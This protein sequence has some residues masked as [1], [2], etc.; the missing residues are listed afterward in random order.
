V[1]LARKSLLNERSKTIMISA[2]FR[3][4]KKRANVLGREMAYVETVSG[5][6]IVFLH[7]NPTS[8]YLWRNVIPYLQ[9]LGRCLAPDLI[10]MGDSE[11]LP[12]SGPGSYTLV[13]HSRYLDALLEGLGVNGRVTLVIHDWGGVLGFHWA[14]RH[15]EAVKGIAYMEALVRPLLWAEW[16]EQVRAL[17]QALRSPAGETMVLEHNFF[18][19]S[20]LP[21]MVLRPL[22]AEEMEQY[23]R[24]FAEPGEGRRP[25]L[26]IPRQVPLDGE[27][28]DVAEIVTAYSAWLSQSTVPKL[29]VNGDPGGAL[30]GAE[31][32]FC[33]SWPEQTEVTVRGLH[34][35]QEDSPD[36]LGQAIA[37]WL[38]TLK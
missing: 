30:I 28:A 38:K 16:D 27:P 29:F 36:E 24:P 18:V 8:S 34:F 21:R 12:D 35:L 3:Y 22:T 14:N 11:K 2:A 15:R 19:E 26:S 5:D 17:F 10:G 13:E 1:N 6:P 37:T 20:M 31:R 23:R 33:R 25:T 7:G 32:E 4:D 9:E